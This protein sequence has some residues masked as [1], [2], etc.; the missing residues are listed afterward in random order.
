[1]PNQEDIPEYKKIGYKV[2]FN[3]TFP[4]GSYSSSDISYDYKLIDIEVELVS[5]VDDYSYTY[6]ITSNVEITNIESS[7]S[8][9]PILDFGTGSYFLNHWGI[10]CVNGT[11]HYIYT[12]TNNPVQFF[13]ELS[14]RSAGGA[15]APID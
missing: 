6:R 14:F 3:V 12:K 10:E 7:G 5:V 1:M 11:H 4:S 9:K 8:F 15:L 2:P 13:D